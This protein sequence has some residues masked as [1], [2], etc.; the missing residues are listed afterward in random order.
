MSELACITLTAFVLEEIPADTV[1]LQSEEL[2]HLGLLA[3]VDRVDVLMIR[4]T[5]QD[6]HK[7]RLYLF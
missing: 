6:G 2:L 4:R 5:V 3:D 1:P 7:R